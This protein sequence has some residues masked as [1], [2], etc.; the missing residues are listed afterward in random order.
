[1]KSTYLG[2]LAAAWFAWLALPSVVLAADEPAGRAAAEPDYRLASAWWGE[3]PRKW[4]PV[5]W[6]NHLFRY[7]V[8]F[9]GAIA[10]Q[11]DLNRRTT[12]WAGQ[13][14]LLW[15]STADPADYAAIPQ[16]WSADHDAPLLWTD[17]G[18]SP[19]AAP[20]PRVRGSARRCSPTSPARRT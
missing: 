13:G 9:N 8:L 18:Q 2:C 5:G 6:K 10:A 15:P 16:G 12:Q 17:W 7:N 1:M 14:M 4:T 11:P 19:L 3:L 20:R